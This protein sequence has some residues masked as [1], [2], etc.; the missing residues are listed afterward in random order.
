MKL[1]FAILLT[2]IPAF[3]QT[4]TV[5]FTPPTPGVVHMVAGSLTCDLTGNAV[6]ATVIHVACSIGG[7][8]IVFDIPIVVGNSFTADYHFNGD[9]VTFTFQ[10]A[11]G[12][13]ITWSAAAT[14][15]GGMTASGSGN[16]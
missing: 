5:V 16:F 3:S 11:A 9:A 13:P 4:G 10:R 12:G 14:P 15:N 2:A 7:T 6:P 1:L 8:P